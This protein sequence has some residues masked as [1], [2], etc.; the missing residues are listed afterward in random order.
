MGRLVGLFGVRGELK[1]DL[2]VGDRP[3]AAVGGSMRVLHEDG[4]A[5]TVT[6]RSLRPH[7]GRWLV[8]FEGIMGADAAQPYVGASVVVRKDELPP[9]AEG[10]YYDHQLVGC[11]LVDTGPEGSGAER[12]LGV[13]ARIEH[14]P[15]SDVLVLESGAMVPLVRAYQPRIDL[16]ERRVVMA[17]PPGLIDPSQ[18]E[19]A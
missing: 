14:W 9:L 4:R 3:T 12:S 6:V 19:Q 2:R 5:E 13:I 18:G 17:L 10:E 11:M 16:A 8:A 7:A 1:L 15:A